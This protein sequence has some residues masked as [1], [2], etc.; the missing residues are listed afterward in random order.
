[1]SF[2]VPPTSTNFKMRLASTE[3][4]NDTIL[5]SDGNDTLLGGNGND[6]ILGEAGADRIEGGLGT[7][8]L[9]GGG[10]GIPRDPA[11]TILGSLSEINETFSFLNFDALL[12]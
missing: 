5:G 2:E 3:T 10:N 12:V 8:R 7:D 4:G 11:D 9:A 1:M 6:L